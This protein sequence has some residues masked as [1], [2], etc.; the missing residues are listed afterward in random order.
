LMQAC[1]VASLVVRTIAPARELRALAA[2]R[3]ASERRASK[4]VPISGNRARDLLCLRFSY[5]VEVKG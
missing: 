1:Y 3:A 2:A 5:L 4:F